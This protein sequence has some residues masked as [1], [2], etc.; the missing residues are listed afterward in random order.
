MSLR[1][2]FAAPAY[3]HVSCSDLGSFW[4]GNSYCI[5]DKAGFHDLF[6]AAKVFGFFSHTPFTHIQPTP[7]TTCILLIWS[8]RWAFVLVA[9]LHSS[10]SNSFSGLSQKL[11]FSGWISLAFVCKD[12]L[13]VLQIYCFPPFSPCTVRLCLM[14]EVAA[15]FFLQISH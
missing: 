12:L 15:I 3:G 10:Q 5:L 8:F 4:M 14:I 1:H 6:Y 11:H 13:H 9:Y 2:C 7:L